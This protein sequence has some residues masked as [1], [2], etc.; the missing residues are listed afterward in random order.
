MGVGVSAV[1]SWC[2]CSEWPMLKLKD[3][4]FQL[5]INASILSK[6]FYKNTSGTAA[7]TRRGGGIHPLSWVIPIG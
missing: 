4:V 7:S 1:N 5:K 3:Y 2:R 6:V